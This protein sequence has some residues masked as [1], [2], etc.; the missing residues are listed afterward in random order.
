MLLYKYTRVYI[1][2]NFFLWKIL[3]FIEIVIY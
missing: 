3:E 1:Y 2:I